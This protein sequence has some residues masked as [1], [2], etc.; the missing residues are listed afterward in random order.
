MLDARCGATFAERASTSDDLHQLPGT[1]CESCRQLISN[2]S[3]Q[4]AERGS[5]RANHRACHCSPDPF[6][7][8]RGFQEFGERLRAERDRKQ[9]YA[10]RPLEFELL[11]AAKD[12][13][14]TKAEFL[15]LHAQ[16]AG[17]ILPEQRETQLP[18]RQ[19]ALLHDPS[20]LAKT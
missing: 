9:L 12:E 2:H 11:A 8:K 19:A 7:C 4:V 10:G 5:F 20:A 17:R 15:A 18:A 3:V 6:G 16:C 13:E 1:A 14:I